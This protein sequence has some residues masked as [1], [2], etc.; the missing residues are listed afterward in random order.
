MLAGGAGVVLCASA[1][2]VSVAMWHRSALLSASVL[3]AGATIL[4]LTWIYGRAR[5]AAM[6]SEVVRSFAGL[7]VIHGNRVVA[8]DKRS[9]LVGAYGTRLEA[10]RAAAATNKWCVLI[11]AWDRYYVLRGKPTRAGVP[12][13]FRTRAVA[14]VVPAPRRTA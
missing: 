1:A 11:R 12:V 4:L 9:P 5:T 10:A 14:D 13:S 6:Q 2:L 3:A 8:I 7:A